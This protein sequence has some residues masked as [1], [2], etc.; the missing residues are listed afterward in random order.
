MPRIVLDFFTT[1]V[2]DKQY[3]DILYLLGF[4]TGRVGRHMIDKVKKESEI[5]TLDNT[6]KTT[7][8]TDKYSDICPACSK[9]L[10]FWACEAICHYCGLKFTC[11]E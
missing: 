4:S 10:E 11:D 9:R 7:N 3:T 8:L 6:D 1:T 2:I 5:K